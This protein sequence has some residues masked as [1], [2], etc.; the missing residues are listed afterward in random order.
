[1]HDS[2]Q[3]KQRFRAAAPISLQLLLLLAVLVAAIAGTGAFFIQRQQSAARQAAEA[4]L[5]SVAELKAT[6][7]GSWIHER[8]GDANVVR[9]SLRVQN[10]LVAPDNPAALAAARSYINDLRE[11][12]DYRL[13][14]LFDSGGKLLLANSTNELQGYACIPAHIQ[15]GLQTQQVLLTDLHRGGTNAPIHFSLV[16][17]VRTSGRTNGPA[18]GVVLLVVDPAQFLYPFLQSWPVPSESGETLLVERDGDDLL[19]LSE[20]RHRPGTALNLRVPLTHTEVPG[21]RAALGQRGIMEGKDHRGV[22]VIAAAHEISGTPWVLGAKL[23]EAEVLAPIRHVLWTTGT[24]FGLGLVAL[25]LGLGLVW[26]QQRLHL[27]EQELAERQQVERALRTS[28][29]HYRLLSENSSDVIWLFDVAAQRFTYVSPSVERLRGYEASEVLHQRLAE[30]MTPAS[31]EMVAAALPARLT[32][33]AA[34][35]DSVRTQTH[36]V[37]QTRR[38]GSTVPTEVV[39]TL[40]AGPDRRVARILGVSRNIAQRKAAEQALRRS[41]QKFA[42]VFKFS[43]DA[44]FLATLP[45]RRLVEVNEALVRMAGYASEELLGRTPDELGFWVQPEQ[46]ERYLATLR[47]TGRVQDFETVLQVKSGVRLRCLVSTEAVHLEGQPH[48]LTV[49]RDVTAARNAEELARRQDTRLRLALEAA[50]MVT[51]ELD[52]ASGRLTYSSNLA[53]MAGSEELAPYLTIESFTDQL[54]PDDRE[55]TRQAIARTLESGQI[56]DC[57]YRIRLPEG[58]WH[59]LAGKGRAMT[60]GDGRVTLVLGVSQDITERRRMQQLLAEQADFIQRVFDSTDAHEAVVG[61]DGTIL[62]V[63]EAWRRFGCENQAGEPPRWGVGARYFE[64]HLEKDSDADAQEAHEGLVRVQRGELERFELEYACHSPTEQR[65]FLMRVVPLQGQAGTVLVSHVDISASKRAQQELNAAHRERERLHLFRETLLSAIPTP[66]FYKDREGRYLGCNRA[67]TEMMGVTAEDIRGKTVYEV[68]PSEFAE[69]YHRTDLELLARP[70]RQSY[71]FKVRDQHGQERSVVYVKDVFRDEAGQPAGIVGAFLDISERERAEAQYRLLAENTE[72]LISVHDAQENRTYISPSFYRVTGWTPEEVAGSSWDE[73]LHPDDLEA[74]KASRAANLAG[75]STAIEHRIRCRDGTWIW[76]EAR[77]KPIPGPDGRVSRLL[78][79]ARE[80]TQRKRAEEALQESERLR[81]LILDTIPDP[82]WMKGVDG[83]YVTVNR[84]WCELLGIP[85]DRAVG[86]YDLEVFPPEVGLRFRQEEQGA[87]LGGR[88]ICLEQLVPGRDGSLRHYET[89]ISPATDDTG[90]AYATIGIARDITARRAAEAAL[91]AREELFS[92]IVGQAMDAIVLVDAGRGSFAEFNTAAH[93][94]LGY[95]RE[96]FARL[97][98]EDI[99]ADHSPE[100]ILQNMQRIREEGGI[101]FESR[102]RHRDGSTRDVRVS[103]RMIRLQARDYMAAVWSDITERKRAER[104]LETERQR[105]ASIIFGSNVGTWEWNIQTGETVFNERWAEMAGYT[106]AELAPVSI[107]TWA[108]LAH[109]DDIQASNALLQQHFRGDVD[110]YECEARI[111]HKAGHWIWVADRGR[112]TSWTADRQPRLMQGTHTDITA[113]KLAEAAMQQSEAEFRTTF[114]LASVGMSQTDPQTGQWVRVNARFCAITGYSLEELREKQTREITHE[115]D[116]ERDWELYQRVVRGEQPDYQIEK[117][118]VRKDGQVVWVNVNMT[119]I[120]DAEGRP[121][122]TMAVVED[123]TERKRAESLRQV[124]LSLGQRLTGTQDAPSAAR[125]LLDAADH[126]WQWDAANLSLISEDGVQSLPV[127]GVDVIDGRR[128]ELPLEER[129]ELTARMRRVIHQGALLIL[130]AP[131]APPQTDSARFGDVTR[132]SASIMCVPIRRETKTVGVLSVQSYTPQAYSQADLDTLQTLADYCGGALERI[133]SEEDLRESERRFRILIEGAPE[134]VFVQSQGRFVFLNPHMLTLLG[135]SRAEQLLGTNF[136]ERAAPEFRAAITGRIAAQ[137]ETGEPAAPMEQEY[138]RLDGSRVP[139]EATAVPVQF[140]GQ[141]AHLVFVRD[142]TE[143]KKQ[144]EALVRARDYYLSLLHG[145]PALVWRAGLDTKCDWFNQTWLDF[146]GRSLEQERGDGWV[147]G[148]HRDDFGHCSRHYLHSFE[149]QEPFEMEYRLR[150]RSGEYRWI[151]DFGV[152]LKNLDGTFAGFIGYC[153]D[154]TARKQAEAALR[155]S[156]QRFRGYVDQAADGIFVVGEQGILRDVNQR[157]CEALGF[158]REELLGL[159]LSQIEVRV[160]PQECAQIMARLNPGERLTIQG[161]HRRKDGST[162]PVEVR[163]AVYELSGQKTFVALARDVTEREQADER[164]RL[165]RDLGFGANIAADQMA[166]LELCMD[167]AVRIAG[168]DAGGIYLLEKATGALVLQ[169]HTGLTDAFR[170]L[171]SHLPADTPQTQHAQRGVRY[172]GSVAAL[173]LPA[174]AAE[175]A[176]G[177]KSISVLPIMEGGEL[178]AVLNV[179]S[180]TLEDIPPA[181]RDALETVAG[182][183]AGLLVRLRAQDAVRQMNQELEQ[184]VAARTREL[185]RSEHRFRAIFQTSRD[186]ILSMNAQGRFT[187][188]NPAA[189]AMFGYGNQAEL[190]AAGVAGLSPEFQPD[191]RSSQDF[192]VTSMPRV[193]AEGGAAFEWTHLRRD[194]TAFPA[195]VSIAV[196]DDDGAPVMHGIVRD[197]SQRRE[198]EARLRESEQR[199]RDLVET[200]PDWVWEVDDQGR[201]VFSGPQCRELLGYEPEEIQGRSLFEFMPPG[202]VE[203]FRRLVSG[204]ANKG[205]VLRALENVMCRK[206]GS[207]VTLETHAAPVLGEGGRVRGYRGVDHDITE[208]K[209]AENEIRRQASLIKS[210]L[211][212]IPD[213]IFFKNV[214][215]VYLGCNPAFARFLGRTEAEIVGHTDHEMV[216][217]EVADSF[218]AH[219]QR[220]MASLAPRQNEEWIE[221]PDGRRALVDTLKTPYWGPNGEMLGVLG[222]SRDI[223]ERKQAELVLRKLWSA[224]E[225]SPTT[226]VITDHT[227]TIE[228]VNPRFERETGYTAAEA[229]GQNPRMLQSGRHTPQFYADLW[230]TLRAGQ[231]WRGEFCN[232]RK[233]GSLF[234]EATAIAPIFDGKGQ[235][236]HFVAIKE[237]VTERRRVAEELRQAKEKAEAANRAKSVFLAN[238]SHEIRTPM[239]AVLGFTQL[240]LRDVN[241]E[242]ERRERLSSIMRSG[243]H[244]MDIIN[245]ILEMAR[246]ETGR[247]LAPSGSLQPDGAAGRPRDDVRPPRPRSP[248]RTERRASPG[249]AALARG[250]SDQAPPDPHQPARQRVQ[251]HSRRRARHAARAGAARSARARPPPGGG[252]GHRSRHPA[253]GFGEC[254]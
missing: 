185:A 146:T 212:S 61:P 202:G 121:L 132:L 53:V 232:R 6:Q 122:R 57:E 241:Q 13:I 239:N 15:S 4:T 144:A 10:Y 197:V 80:I 124:L 119:L 247:G 131:D 178:L 54:H 101:V 152:P 91:R 38:D 160:Q 19:Y 55:L 168:C 68:W 233:D 108:R 163:L 150:H 130:R 205:G 35:D 145:A 196:A 81:R 110:G 167:S 138:L 225:Q 164:S 86:S 79:S 216:P 126:L 66:V 29:A 71:D 248:V 102:H 243:E 107:E 198:A 139:V 2:H 84:A 123:I 40:I 143:R 117:R 111:R 12:Y 67:F 140:Q 104:A 254:V 191:G 234:W 72:D 135:A 148:V 30:V 229:I 5:G 76:V 142:V 24:A 235:A 176:E 120:R 214:E 128:Q 158:T 169:C 200:I 203:N 161:R 173:G 219:D 63:N 182:L 240:L 228:Y 113:R 220:M 165:L 85:M 251:V 127:I 99:Q 192:F 44:I 242:P 137:R 227:A 189:L 3:A 224:V 46:R 51:W 115:L 87:L 151:V 149:R 34:G 246:I 70:G 82:A 177:F 27:L 11:A 103:I 213:L 211:D 174:H 75:Q 147:E 204:V 96:E 8:Q 154:I 217:R 60:N 65:W 238:M 25:L 210:L 249:F 58:S 78:I 201:Y 226:V 156:E 155:E 118:Y 116:R 64:T 20:P 195:E 181:A 171:V 98:V 180:H 206:D 231:T 22:A 245:E 159:D 74:I 37:E 183:L 199:H 69:M 230:R 136:L 237:D 28:E 134:G 89:N 59:W 186:A 194:G 26:R 184:R 153:Y 43:P 1:M 141:P 244:L 208:R 106:L 39:T 52:A 223:T 83:R 42:R 23:D 125:A 170:K 41:E 90:V 112:V 48:V 175:R 252:R 47:E 56:F 17:P 45:E 190:L 105:L 221:Y 218:R 253:G 94:G 21:V 33:F 88:A 157:A 31:L 100:I 187:D 207:P 166:A 114:E 188:C 7:I 93:E 162:L 95:T 222:I 236:T 14:A 32:A 179:A 9:S 92:T 209:R 16:C 172:H 18:D 49:V 97:T 215:G 50:G 250:G 129:R 193:L 73:R 62:R 36:E 77:S 133:R 109:P